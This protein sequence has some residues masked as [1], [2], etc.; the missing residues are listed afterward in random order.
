MFHKEYARV[1]DKTGHTGNRRR[2]GREMD[3][4]GHTGL[5]SD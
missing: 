3:K 2:E 5:G 1:M 4:T